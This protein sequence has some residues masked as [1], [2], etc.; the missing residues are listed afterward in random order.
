MKKLAIIGATGL[1]GQT[2]LCVLKE[3]N[4]IDKFDV[5]LIV[6]NR[7]AGKVIVFDEKH[8]NL[9]ELN[10]E[11][12]DLNFDFALFVAQEDISKVWVKRFAERGTVVIDNSSIFRLKE[13][14]PL[15]VPEINFD[16]VKCD[17]KII[18]NPNC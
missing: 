4:L 17:E 6:S 15:I 14:V 9:F 16:C 3:E 7:S 2:T 8:Y 12:L 18:A 13:N 5:Y 10:E 1:V 11:I